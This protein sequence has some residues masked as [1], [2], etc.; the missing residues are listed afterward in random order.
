MA[1]IISVI[2]RKVENMKNRIKIENVDNGFVLSR[3]DIPYVDTKIYKFDEFDELVKYLRF[4]YR[5]V[6]PVT[7]EETT[8]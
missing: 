1:I 7:Q 8:T 5:E 3:L 2:S 6:L 4:V